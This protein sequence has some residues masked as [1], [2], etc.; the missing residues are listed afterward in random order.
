M[1]VVLI[2]GA[3]VAVDRAVALEDEAELEPATLFYNSFLEGAVTS[4]LVFD[5]TAEELTNQDVSGPAWIV[6]GC[7]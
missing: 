2:F 7:A 1:V 6:T 5:A 3:V 4:R